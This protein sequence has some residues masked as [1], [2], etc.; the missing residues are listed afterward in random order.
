MASE[1]EDVL[2]QASSL[3]GNRQPKSIS[4]IINDNKGVIISFLSGALLSVLS[5]FD[6]PYEIFLGVLL[7]MLIWYTVSEGARNAAIIL[8]RQKGSEAWRTALVSFVDLTSVLMV[9]F[10]SQYLTS[11]ATTEW[12]KAGF[13]KWDTVFVGIFFISYAISF[14]VIISAEANVQK[15]EDYVEEQRKKKK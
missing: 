5:A 9:M 15:V 8:S 3:F 13:G 6:Q 14:L 7:A 4:Q 11:V 1:P 2:P 10:F 12:E